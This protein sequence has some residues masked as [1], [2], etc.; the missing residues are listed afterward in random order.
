M[1]ESPGEPSAALVAALVKILR[2]LVRLLMSHGITLPYC[3]NLLKEIYVEVAEQDFTLHGKSQTD[4]RI[5][6]I[7]GVHRKDV[8]RMRSV[9]KSDTP[10]PSA[11]SMGAQV[12]ATWVSEKKYTDASGAPKQLPIRGSGGRKRSF[13]ELVATV[14][15]QD[16]RP[17]VVLDELLRL[18]IVE[19]T[20]DEIVVLKVDAFVPNS[21]FDEK[22]H[23]F[24]QNLRDH[25]AAAAHNLGNEQT[26][27]LERAVSYHNLSDAD[28][29]KLK[30]LAEDLAM[31]ALKAVNSRAR[32]MQRRSQ[33]KLR[34]NHRMN[35][36]AY[37]FSEAVDDNPVSRDADSNSDDPPE[38]G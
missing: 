35:F 32:Q 2:P 3:S 18:G 20:D 22:A 19:V 24:G 6:L 7:T 38:R 12:I 25:I 37:L 5:S 36:G 14:S 10:P 30:A 15:R 27:F 26:K 28:V 8:R 29:I 11:V 21:G 17:R 16:L 13:E 34:A 4:S 1:K 23:Y 33:T 31:D 9:E